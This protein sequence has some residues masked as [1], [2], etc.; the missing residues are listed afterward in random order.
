MSNAK[1]IMFI[2]GMITLSSFADD[3]KKTVV[4]EKK[5]KLDFEAK[6]VDGEFL[7]PEAQDVDGEKNIDFASMLEP[8]ANFKKELKRSA[9]A[10]R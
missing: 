10:V 1:I 4:Y 7:K 3:K 8:R 6:S 5:T 9:G 2:L